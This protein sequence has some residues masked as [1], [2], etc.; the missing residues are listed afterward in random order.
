M[1]LTLT[2]RNALLMAIFYAIFKNPAHFYLIEFNNRNT[3]QSCMI[4]SKLTKKP[5]ERRHWRR[6]GVFTVIFEQCHTYTSVSV[7]DFEEIN[8]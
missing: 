1:I 2:P 3:R 7:V 8:V 5:L 6:S 4:R